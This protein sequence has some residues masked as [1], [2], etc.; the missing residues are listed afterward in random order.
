MESVL[1]AFIVAVA[2]MLSSLLLAT[3]TNRQRRR[4]KLEDYARQDAVADKAAEAAKLLLA[5]NER[6]AETAKITNGK[7]DVIHT[8]VNS[9]MTAAMQSE[10]DATVREHAMM[11]EVV[12]LK[13][14]AGQ[15]PNVTSLAAIEAT[16]RKIAE[17]Q[18]ALRDR[19]KQV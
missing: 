17:L 8:L 5:A 19:L 11:V 12:A 7:L 4:E 14:N 6:V 2:S 3:L 10:L 15:E 9:N 1:I 13:R 18:A 16:E